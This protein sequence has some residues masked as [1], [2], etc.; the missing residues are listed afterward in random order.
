MANN[1][2]HSTLTVWKHSVVPTWPLNASMMKLTWT[3]STHSMHFCTTWLPFWSL[4]HFWT[5]PS[6]SFTI[7]TWRPP[8]TFNYTLAFCQNSWTFHQTAFTSWSSGIGSAPLLS[9]GYTC[10]IQKIHIFQPTS[11]CISEMKPVGRTTVTEECQKVTNV[12]INIRFSRQTKW[13]KAYAMWSFKASKKEKNKIKSRA[14][15]IN[16]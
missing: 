16:D 12:A 7:S 5:W 6:S 3:G 4:I 10:D 2:T 9:T 14:A 15:D 11:P 13:Y 1:S 8:K